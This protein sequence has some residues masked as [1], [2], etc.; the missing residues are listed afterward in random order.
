MIKEGVGMNNFEYLIAVFLCCMV[1]A[2]IGVILNRRS[3]L[4]IGLGIA[5]VMPI[6]WVFVDGSALFLI[7]TPIFALAL[8]ICHR[9]HK[10][11]STG[12]NK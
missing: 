1:G 5:T 7:A 8:W 2:L 6:G 11:P 12:A 10:R 4:I 3:P 9:H